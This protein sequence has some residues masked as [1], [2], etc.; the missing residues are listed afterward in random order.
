MIRLVEGLLANG[1]AYRGEDGSVYFAI[2][3]FPAYGGCRSWT[4]AS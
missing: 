4:G 3:R 2:A 1:T